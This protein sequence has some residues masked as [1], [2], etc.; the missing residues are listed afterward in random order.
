MID[1]EKNEKYV[2]L[3]LVPVDVY[4]SDF[5]L[6]D[7]VDPWSDCNRAVGHIYRVEDIKGRTGETVEVLV[8]KTDMPF[9]DKCFVEE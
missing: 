4:G 6:S 9:F 7:A 1:E 3:R 8:K 5:G 2:K